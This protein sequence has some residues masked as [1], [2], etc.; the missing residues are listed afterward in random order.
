MYKNCI[1]EL[2]RRV[3]KKLKSGYFLF[4]DSPYN[5]VKTAY[6]MT[7]IKAQKRVEC[8]RKKEMIKGIATEK[9]LNLVR[10]AE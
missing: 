6:N 5:R 3:E 7:E 8:N 10:N 9:L 4:K 1:K 2:Y